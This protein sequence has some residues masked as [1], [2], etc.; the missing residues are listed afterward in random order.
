M[1]LSGALKRMQR[2]EALAILEI[3]QQA[4]HHH[5]DGHQS[6]D[7][8]MLKVRQSANQRDDHA[9]GGEHGETERIDLA[10]LDECCEL[11]AVE[12]LG[13]GKGSLLELRKNR[14]ELYSAPGAKNLL[15]F[16]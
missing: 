12:S 7:V 2:T 13:H 4:Q 6:K 8:G 9:G 10:A 1:F 11:F 15:K 3:L 16:R 14:W 5:R